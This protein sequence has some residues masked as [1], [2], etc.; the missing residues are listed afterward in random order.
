MEPCRVHFVHPHL[1]LERGG[2][3]HQGCDPAELQVDGFEQPH[4]IGLRTYVCLDGNGAPALLLN[5]AHDVAGFTVLVQ[6]IYADRVT[7]AG[8]QAHSGG[9]NSTATSSND[10]NLRAGANWFVHGPSSMVLF[11]ELVPMRSGCD[12]GD[13]PH[14]AFDR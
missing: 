10:E 9:S 1:T 11:F 13:S 7:S 14:L 4:H 6:I 3:I 12:I 8:C 2:V 5:R